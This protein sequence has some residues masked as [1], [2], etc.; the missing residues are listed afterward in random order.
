MVKEMLESGGVD[1]TVISNFDEKFSESFGERAR[2]SPRNLIS[3]NKFQVKT[4]EV[5][6]KVDPKRTDLI[7]TSIIDGEKYILISAEEGVEVNGINV[8]MTDGED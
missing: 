7:K 8:N 2:I 1:E 5:V 4:P 3:T 6:I